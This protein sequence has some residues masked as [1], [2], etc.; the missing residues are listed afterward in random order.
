MFAVL[1]ALGAYLVI[2]IGEVPFTLQTFFVYLVGLVL[3]PWAAAGSQLL[4]LLLGTAGLPVFAGGA[5]GPQVLLSPV[6]GFLLAFPLAALTE[7]LISERGGRWKGALS[8]AAGF[9]VVFGLGIGFFLSYEGSVSVEA[10]VVGFAP[11]MIWDAVKAALAY[12]VGLRLPR[13]LRSGTT[14]VRP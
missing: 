3:E 1:M 14:S 12:T 10:T 4:Y 5:S 6:G 9:S 11:L 8:L 2:P 7:S 13:I